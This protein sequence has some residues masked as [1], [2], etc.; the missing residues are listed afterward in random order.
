ME[1]LKKIVFNNSKHELILEE[2]E[3]AY[4]LTDTRPNIDWD[5]ETIAT[6]KNVRENNAIEYFDEIVK[7]QDLYK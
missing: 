7:N 5:K 2:S 6:K 1:I 4:H 3:T